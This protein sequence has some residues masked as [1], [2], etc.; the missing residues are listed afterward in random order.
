MYLAMNRRTPTIP[1]I[2]IPGPAGEKTR[3]R[4]W[5]RRQR[6]QVDLVSVTYRNMPV[7]L[8]DAIKSIADDN[9][10]TVNDIARLFLN[11]ALEAY[12]QGKL[13][14]TPVLQTGKYTLFPKKQKS[15]RR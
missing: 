3:S 4:D 1:D 12:D 9:L 8:R 15:S 5:E 7:E 6:Q 11:Y 2:S 13:T 10:V 14:L